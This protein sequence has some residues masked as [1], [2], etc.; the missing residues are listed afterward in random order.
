M[1][2]S[3]F[4]EV[5]LDGEQG[6]ELNV[7]FLKRHNYGVKN[8]FDSIVF[9]DLEY[10][11]RIIN[12][13]GHNGYKIYAAYYK[14]EIVENIRYTLD[15]AWDCFVDYPA[16]DTI[17]EFI[18]REL[19]IFMVE[20]DNYQIF[21]S[22]AQLRKIDHYDYSDEYAKKILNEKNDEG[23]KRYYQWLYDTYQH[24]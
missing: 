6:N 23:A 9:R 20:I 21:G 11:D 12:Q 3:F 22:K 14:Q 2:M 19:F 8:V 13:E 1:E 18:G 15:E 5:L 17:F 16:A 7:D 10:L 4:D 24:L